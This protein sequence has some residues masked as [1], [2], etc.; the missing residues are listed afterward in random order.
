[1]RQFYL[2]LFLICGNIS[3]GQNVSIVFETS[4]GKIDKQE[5]QSSIPQ[6]QIEQLKFYVGQFTFL[7]KS[8]VVFSAPTYY[9][10]DA[11]DGASLSISLEVPKSL[12]YDEWRFTLGVDSATNDSGAQGGSLD[13]TSGMYWSWQSGYINFKLEGNFID[14]METEEFQYHLGGFLKGE[15][16]AK[17]VIFK[18]KNQRELKV[19]LN[20]EPFFL[21]VLESKMDHLMSPGKDAVYLMSIL[22]NSFTLVE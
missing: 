6:I 1:M 17:E 5:K 16:S 12:K 19:N 22:Q 18:G 8:K 3:F 21:K 4:L 20:L 15:Q 10:L 14:S 7:H 13:P 9:L 11:N 2:L